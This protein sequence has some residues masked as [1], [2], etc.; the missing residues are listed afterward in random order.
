MSIWEISERGWSGLTHRS[1]VYAGLEE[2]ERVN[3]VR[4]HCQQPGPRGGRPSESL[5]INPA[6]R[7]RGE[8]GF[9]G[10]SGDRFSEKQSGGEM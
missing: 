8:G 9:Q 10:P 5:R 3:W 6:V 7:Y 1:T 4:I 2:L